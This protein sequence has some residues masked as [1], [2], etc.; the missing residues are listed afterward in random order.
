MLLSESP[1]NNMAG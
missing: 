1:V